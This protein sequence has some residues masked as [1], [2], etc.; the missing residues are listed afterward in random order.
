MTFKEKWHQDHPGEEFKVFG[1]PGD[2]WNCPYKNGYE[3]APDANT[4]CMQPCMNCWN[5]E[6]PGT[7]E[8]PHILDSGERRQF[9]TG[10]VRD[11]QEGKGRCDLMPLE[12][13]AKI[14]NGDSLYNPDLVVGRIAL[15]KNSDYQETAPHI[16][17]WFHF[18][19]LWPNRLLDMTSTFADMFLEVSK[20]F[21]EGAKKYGENNWQKGLPIHCCINSAVRHY[22]KWLRGDTDEPHDRAFIWNV[23]CCIWECDYSPRAT[24]E[25]EQDAPIM[26]LECVTKA[27]SNRVAYL[28]D[29]QACT[30]CD[31]P[32]CTHT[33][34]IEHA[35]NFESVGGHRF[36]EREDVERP[37]SRLLIKNAAPGVYEIFGGTC[38]KGA[39]SVVY[40]MATG[41]PINTNESEFCQKL[42]LDNAYHGVGGLI[43]GTAPGGALFYHENDVWLRTTVN[44]NT[45]SVYAVRLCDGKPKH[46]SAVTLVTSVEDV[47]FKP[48]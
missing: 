7:K 9:E 14:L 23:L 26:V 30:V 3:A 34:N 36:V 45:E 4:H 28:C 31:N 37:S 21:E 16:S 19:E 29:R 11:I 15:F 12:V 32:D 17:A 24:S 35:V 5:R 33:E 6:M 20:H 38:L 44:S 22:L 40:D 48:C 43:L 8:K 25:T 42:S 41:C 1:A 10:A 39:D 2:E 18:A 13:V 27:Q 47:D 46:F